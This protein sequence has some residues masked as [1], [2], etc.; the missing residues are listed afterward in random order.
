MGGIKRRRIKG[1]V[2][3]N[4][5]EIMVI[6]DVTN[7]LGPKLEMLMVVVSIVTINYKRIKQALIE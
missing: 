4:S 6:K 5:E 2:E 7:Y 1:F 3:T